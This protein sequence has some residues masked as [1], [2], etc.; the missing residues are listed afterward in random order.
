MNDREK[1]LHN[2]KVR[3]ID[4]KQLES[5]EEYVHKE[6]VVTDSEMEALLG[7]TFALATK[8]K[9]KSRMD[10]CKACPK[11]TLKSICSECGCFMQAKTR[12]KI[13]SCPEQKW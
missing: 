2:E 10:I 3:A 7:K 9:A 12:L 1:A 5:K 4:A 13:S 8:E 11:L 6:I